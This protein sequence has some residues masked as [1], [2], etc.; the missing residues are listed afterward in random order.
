[1]EGL[2]NNNSKP[3]WKYIKSKKQDFIGVAPQKDHGKLFNDEKD[4]AEILVKQFQSVFTTV[5]T[6]ILPTTNKLIEN[7]IS[8]I[9]V[10]NAGLVKLLKDINP[11]KA[12]GPDEIPNRILKECAVQIAPGL[13]KNISNVTGHRRTTRRMAKCKHFMCL[14]KGDKH[15]AENYRPVSLTSVPCKILEHIICKHLLN[16]LDHHNVITS[17]IHGFRSGYSCETQ[18]LVTMQTL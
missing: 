11:S 1:M 9:T 4:K 16:H 15:A 8:N 7:N 5:K 18:L 3:F 13:A 10:I 14:Q 2:Q 6:A 17:L 12:S